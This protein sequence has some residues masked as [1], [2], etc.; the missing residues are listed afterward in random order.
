MCKCNV[1][2]CLQVAPIYSAYPTQSSYAL[3]GVRGKV[4]QQENRVCDIWRAA[5][6][7]QRQ[8]NRHQIMNSI[9]HHIFWTGDAVH[10]LMMQF[11]DVFD[12]D[13]FD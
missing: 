13:V 8:A 10:D 3:V 2:I 7:Q 5:D 1:N 12:L 6:E 9:W 11:Q 4:S